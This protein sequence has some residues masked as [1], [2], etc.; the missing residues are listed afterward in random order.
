MDIFW[1]LDPDLQNN[2]C[3]SATLPVR[4]LKISS[5]LHQHDPDPQHY[6]THAETLNHPCS[7]P[8]GYYG[9]HEAG[10]LQAG[11]VTIKKINLFC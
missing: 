10:G 11:A 2:R 5:D 1:I 6:P 8:K 7:Y 9:P 4:I 3:G